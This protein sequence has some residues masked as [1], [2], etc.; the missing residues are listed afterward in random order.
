MN[1]ISNGKRNYE[2]CMNV[3][4]VF[5]IVTKVDYFHKCMTSIRYWLFLT[6]LAILLTKQTQGT[7]K[8]S[9]TFLTFAEESLLTKVGDPP[10][11]E[12][13]KKK[14][15]AFVFDHKLKMKLNLKMPV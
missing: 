15:L 10:C 14:E 2:R 1:T 5:L 8:S 7:L 11:K 13:E 12:W 6:S 4:C 9:W 3:L